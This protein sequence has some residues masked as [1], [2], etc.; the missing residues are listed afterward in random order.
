MRS[1]IPFPLLPKAGFVI[2]K[3]FLT[4]DCL[5]R[6]EKFKWCRLHNFPGP[7]I[8][9]LNCPNHYPHLFCGGL[10]GWHSFRTKR[11]GLLENAGSL[12]SAG[13]FYS[14]A[15]DGSFPSRGT[16]W[17]RLGT[18]KKAAAKSLFPEL[19]AWAWGLRN[20]HLL[21]MWDQSMGANTFLVLPEISCG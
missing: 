8:P 17:H 20:S 11:K 3:P 4:D 10:K 1:L 15:K 14:D 16:L 19:L 5:A 12:I 21:V 2:L 18:W 7:S 6:S 9:V 13:W